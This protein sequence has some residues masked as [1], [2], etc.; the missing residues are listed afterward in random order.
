LIIA[1]TIYLAVGTSNT[2]VGPW[3]VDSFPIAT[4]RGGEYEIA[5]RS[6]TTNGY[7]ISKMLVLQ[8]GGNGY[9][10]EYGIV[11]SNGSLGSFTATLTG[12]NFLLN[13][14]PVA[15]MTVAYIQGTKV[16]I[17]V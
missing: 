9:I 4:Y 11:S 3:Q 13:F 10:T 16:L 17:S 8:D 1:N 15:A 7:Q 12:G 14:T 6:G 5:I 2:G